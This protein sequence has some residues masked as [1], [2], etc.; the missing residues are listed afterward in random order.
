METPQVS[1]EKLDELAEK[2]VNVND[3]LTN[4]EGEILLGVLKSATKNDEKIGNMEVMVLEML[5]S[6]VLY[7]FDRLAERME[8]LESQQEDI[9]HRID[10]IGKRL[11]PHT[12]DIENNDIDVE[13]L[14]EHIASLQKNNTDHTAKEEIEKQ[15]K[16]KTQLAKES[17]DLAD[18]QAVQFA[19]PEVKAVYD[20]LMPEIRKELDKMN[21]ELFKGLND[22]GGAVAD[23][24]GTAG[25][26]IS[27]DIGIVARRIDA[28][29]ANLQSSLSSIDS[30]IRDIRSARGG[31][32]RN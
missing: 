27:N 3:D 8:A 21:D 23:L 19:S 16:L 20:A 9:L 18:P 2:V 32:Y 6:Q 24:T 5:T 13:E 4:V 30:K 7:R 11:Q 26:R 15:L 31:V 29:V 25:G 14:T 22:L 1:S 28:H 17:L 12:A 10:R